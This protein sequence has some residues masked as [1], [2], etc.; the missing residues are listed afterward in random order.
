MG[1]LRYLAIV[2]GTVACSGSS[3]P[4]P[5]ATIAVAPVAAQPPAERLAEGAW[6][7][8]NGSIVAVDATGSKSPELSAPLAPCVLALNRQGFYPPE[9]EARERMGEEASLT[10]P[11]FLQACAESY[12][13][14]RPGPQGLTPAQ[15]HDNYANVARCTFETHY[16]KPYWLPELVSDVDLCGRV[17]G[18]DWRLPT[19]KTLAKFNGRHRELLA[20][21]LRDVPYGGGYNSL[22]VYGRDARNRLTLIDIGPA[23][24]KRGAPPR[25]DGSSKGT[26]QA[27]GV[28]LRCVRES[29]A[30]P[31]VDMPPVSVLAAGC[32]AALATEM[33]AERQRA[34]APPQPE[35]EVPLDPALARLSAHAQALNANPDS[36]DPK[37]SLRE[38]ERATAAAKKAYASEVAK[39]T[40]Q[41]LESKA[42]RYNELQRSLE[43]PNLPAAER[44]TRLSEFAELRA[45]LTANAQNLLTPP[46]TRE[47]RVVQEALRTIAQHSH[48]R[49]AR[50]YT[51][52]KVWVVVGKPKKGATRSLA[53][54]EREVQSL[55]KLA[56]KADEI[57]GGNS[58][59]S[60][61]LP[62]K[63]AFQ[64]K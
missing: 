2:L 8:P 48:R 57:S 47:K 32:G 44:A 5:T 11:Y 46:V 61:V 14:T 15:A 21:A 17:L 30:L 12:S 26:F 56:R 45:W 35:P 10:F 37:T 6:F 22:V 50:A 31:A 64:K 7:Q 39:P 38:L 40:Q 58:A 63:S 54:V 9:R 28:A 3:K 42:Q 24:A 18:S 13:I 19:E 1:N 55:Q 49:F 33:A 41:E 53:A 59:D 27:A 36:F 51:E 29:R 60:L 34:S 4:A 16:G 23:D 20:G 43:D 52:Y 62:P 25:L